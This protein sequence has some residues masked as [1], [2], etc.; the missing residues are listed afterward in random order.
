MEQADTLPHAG[1]LVLGTAQLGMDYGVANRSGRPA[2]DA[3]VNLIRTAWTQGIRSFDTAAAYGESETVLGYAFAALGLQQQARVITKGSLAAGPTPLSDAVRRSLSRLQ[4]PQLAAWLLHE[5][6][7]LVDWHGQVLHEARQLQE[8]GI[9]SQFGI[10]VYH[11]SVA[12][13]A[14]EDRGLKAV[15]FP[16]S[17]LD[18]RFLRAPVLR[19]LTAAQPQLYARSIYLQGLCLM[20][21]AEVPPAIHRGREAISALSAFC[22]EHHLAPDQFCL[23]YVLARTAGT[24][25]RL[26]IGLEHPRQL[27]RNVRLMGLAP[28]DPAVY[29]AWDAQW[30]DDIA[31][32]VLPMHWPA[33]R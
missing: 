13:Q 17:P 25:T 20:A 23:H 15:Q 18:R 10:S 27:E 31:D 11:P 32:L 5:E 6:P 4:V 28:P 1:P 21:P 2:P 33:I 29:D 3:A 30:P 22:Q 12:F 24:G 19:R 14:L 8:N 9:V 26:V 7:R 16:A